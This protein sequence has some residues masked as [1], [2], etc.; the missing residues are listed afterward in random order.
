MLSSIITEIEC[1]IGHHEGWQKWNDIFYYEFKYILLLAI[2][3]SI[4]VFIYLLGPYYI[5]QIVCEFWLFTF[6]SSHLIS[7]KGFVLFCHTSE[8]ISTMWCG[9]R[10]F[11]CNICL[12]SNKIMWK[13]SLINVKLELEYALSHCRLSALNLPGEPASA[14]TSILFLVCLHITAL[15]EL[16]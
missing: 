12:I 11:L 6:F 14:S 15:A 7:F 8:F 13:E 10:Y 2:C 16:F 5:N 9:S 1:Q 3:D 4:N